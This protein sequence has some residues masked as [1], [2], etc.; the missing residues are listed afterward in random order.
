M[1]HL[2]LRE[3]AKSPLDHA[4]H[5]R[6]LPAPPL[7]SRQSR[8]LWQ[9]FYAFHHHRRRERFLFNLIILYYIIYLYII[10]ILYIYSIYTIYYIYNIHLYKPCHT[11]PPPYFHCHNCRDCRE[12]GGAKRLNN[13]SYNWSICSLVNPVQW[14]ITWIS[15]PFSF[16]FLAIIV[17][18]AAWPSFKPSFRPSAKPSALP[19]LNE[20]SSAA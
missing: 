5:I 7:H 9:L 15:T 17:R 13:P 19:R 1:R 20:Y 6:H 18:S 16:R 8:Q 2:W 12:R 11:Y 10:Y 3:V 4:T 14:M